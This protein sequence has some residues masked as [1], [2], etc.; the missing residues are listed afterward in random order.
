VDA[1]ERTGA[2][3]VAIADALIRLWR[4]ISRRPVLSILLFAVAVNALWFALDLVHEDPD[5]ASYV[6]PAQHL[7][8]GRGFL[9]E[10]GF[11]G[12]FRTPGYPLVIAAFLGSGL[13]LK[14][15][16]V[17]QHLLSA[18]MA[19]AVF[20]FARR[21]T[22]DNAIAAVA[23]VIFILYLPCL[24]SA[25]L[26]M[27]ETLYS[28]MLLA[29]VW[30]L[31]KGTPGAIALAAVIGGLSVLVRPIGL[32][33]GI[34]LAIYVALAVGRRPPADPP[35]PAKKF[36]TA[37]LFLIL[38][39]TPSTLWTYRNHEKAG[40]AT[41]SSITGENMLY[42]RAAGLEAVHDRGFWYGVLAFQAPHDYFLRFRHAQRPLKKEA[43]RRASEAFGKAP[44]ELSHAQRAIY[45]NEV[46]REVTMRHIAHYPKLFVSGVAQMMIDGWWEIPSRKWGMGYRGAL[47]KF[48]WVGLVLFAAMCIGLWH[49]VRT[50]PVLGILLAI[51]LGYFIVLSAGPGGVYR[52]SVPVAAFY[53][54]AAASSIRAFL[55]KLDRGEL[56]R[57]VSGPTA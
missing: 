49:L 16:I 50:N 48:L 11:P 17:F 36:A 53:A 23:A 56:G 4:A 51:V 15:L 45:Y 30:L 39:F 28:A 2:M 20:L 5:T 1:R 31:W 22:N 54:I 43:E 32:W 19:P 41:L 34:P 55:G 35:S 57:S 46:G 7:L 40:V 18:L 47:P 44:M 42:F 25:N 33:L 12:T 9:D 38:W 10:E 8:A 29:T 21:T 27:A 24:E 52:F 3:V 26:V 13:G 37:S 6:V 14:G